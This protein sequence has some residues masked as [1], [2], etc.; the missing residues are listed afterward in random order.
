M[1]KIFMF[2][3]VVTALFTAH[4]QSSISFP[5]T[6]QHVAPSVIGPGIYAI[7][8][9]NA[10]DKEYFM[11]NT[12]YPDSKKG[13]KLKGMHYVVD[14]DECVTLDNG[15]ALWQV[16]TFGQDKV[17]LYSYAE[18]KYLARKA[19]GKLGLAFASSLSDRALWTCA[20]LSNGN[21]LLYDGGRALALDENDSQVNLFDNYSSGYLPH[22]KEGLKLYKLGAAVSQGNMKMPEN[23]HRYCIAS[24]YTLCLK[25][26]KE[27]NNTDVLLCDGSIAPFDKLAVWTAKLLSDSTFVL[28]NDEGCLDYNL[29]ANASESVWRLRNGY[30]QTEEAEPRYVSYAD[31]AWTVSAWAEMQQ[32]ALL[33]GVA[34]EPGRSVTA[35]GTC[36]LTGGW[37]TTDL[38]NLPFDS[39]KCLDV[40]KAILPKSV[41]PFTQQQ[42]NCPV[43]VAET[44]AA[45]V[46]DIWHFVVLCRNT[47]CE[48]LDQNLVITDKQ[49]LNTDRAITIADGQVCYR[50]VG[51]D[52][53]TWQTLSLPYDAAV[54]SGTA[55]ACTG[56]QGDSLCFERVKALT[57]H[58]GYIIKPSKDGV[59]EVLSAKGHID[60]VS[61]EKQETMLRANEYDWLVVTDNQNACYMLHPTL[62]NFVPA[63]SNS[64][65]APFRAYISMIKNNA[66]HI[67]F[68]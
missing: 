67:K 12:L 28:K 57:A 58:T 9:T 23:G 32:P 66:L 27:Q 5:V 13:T 39:I 54:T 21:V 19:D 31:G 48:L 38:K 52:A 26:G 29:T 68:R 41:K 6:V 40:T 59:I 7:S 53:T 45:A 20:I 34:D 16:E 62:Q 44:Q 25:D 18:Q 35:A 3:L 17:A 11:T 37:T 56:L 1:K 61:V 4:A 55:Y 10:K 14:A 65:L 60:A 46:R 22:M 2:L 63:P 64:H 43:F 51:G 50:R 24:N 47:D 8:S 15:N 30:W 33:K 49:P 36:F 42:Y